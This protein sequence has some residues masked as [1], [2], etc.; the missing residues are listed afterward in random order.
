MS[1]CWSLTLHRRDLSLNKFFSITVKPDNRRDSSILIFW[2]CMPCNYTRRWL[3]LYRWKH[4]CPLSMKKAFIRFCL[5]WATYIVWMVDL[6]I[7]HAHILL[8]IEV[9][10]QEFFSLCSVTGAVPHKV[11]SGTQS[12]CFSNVSLQEGANKKKTT[13][14]E[15][16]RPVSEHLPAFR[17]KFIFF[18]QLWVVAGGWW[19]LLWASD[20][21]PKTSHQSLGKNV[22]SQAVWIVA[23]GGCLP[24]SLAIKLLFF[25]RRK[26][27]FSDNPEGR[28]W[29]DAAIPHI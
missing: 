8:L 28:R 16:H 25:F 12:T 13:A 15:G 2:V 14:T 4:F 11:N 27:V 23:V 18:E 5:F 20:G 6:H 21:W 10:A 9:K 3:L 22:Y 19:H 17:E 29:N 7:K 26:I 1:F 24:L